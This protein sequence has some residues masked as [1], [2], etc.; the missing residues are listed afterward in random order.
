M[1]G[2]NSRIESDAKILIPNL[3]D[4]SIEDIRNG[5]SNQHYSCVELVQVNFTL[6]AIS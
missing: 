6:K 3:M 4:L 1:G 5:L 2:R